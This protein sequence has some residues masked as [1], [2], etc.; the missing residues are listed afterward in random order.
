M[1]RIVLIGAGS[2]NFG[3]GVVG[4]IFKSNFLEGSTIIL[5]DINAKALDNT[6][7]IASEYK[8][9]LGINITIESTTSRKEALKG[10]SFCLISIEVGNRFDLWDQDWKIPLQYGVKQVYG[11]NGGPG[12]LFHSLRIIPPILEIC[13]DIQAICPDAYVFNYSNPMQRVCHAVTTKFPDL[14]FIGL[15]HEIES[16]RRQLPSLMETELSNIEFRAGGL[17]HF[18]ILLDAKFKNNGKDGY[19]LIKKNFWNYFKDLVNDHEGFESE[20]GAERGVFF[21]IYEDFKYLPITT[22]SHLGEYVQW[23]YSVADHEAILHFYDN[24]K[25]KCLNFFENDKIY[26]SF[27]DLENDRF[28]ERFVPIAEAIIE[29]QGIEES[30]VNIPNNGFIDCL[31][32][33]I[34]VEVPAMIDKKG[35]EGITLENY[36]KTFG[37]LL[38]LQSGVIQ[39]TTQAVLEKSKHKAYLALLS[40]PVVA[41]VTD[42]EKLLNNMITVQHKHLSYLN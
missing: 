30:S 6:F 42:A 8:E 3:L 15:C 13:E 2:T 37:S 14:K 38:N 18:S 25:K 32:K 26:S 40:D 21:K 11:E 34:V 16:M 7:K 20:P 19:P 31:P 10:A 12:G 17:N 39:L 41:S 23:A 29:D 27:F 22:D 33:D 24:Y 1:H 9:K 36:P 5:Y 35:I 28:H 4:D